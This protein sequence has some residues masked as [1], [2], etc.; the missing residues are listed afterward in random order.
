MG[1]P[2]SGLP[3]HP[4]FPVPEPLLPLGSVRGAAFWPWGALAGL[5]SGV[6]AGPGW[7]LLAQSRSGMA[8]SSS[9]CVSSSS[10][11]ISLALYWVRAARFSSQS[12]SAALRGGGRSQGYSGCPAPG[13]LGLSPFPQAHMRGMVKAQPPGDPR[14]TP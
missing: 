7:A 13:P 14:T 12:R 2:F 10:R 4:I 1:L 11:L 5:W 6:G 9:A 3:T 8:F